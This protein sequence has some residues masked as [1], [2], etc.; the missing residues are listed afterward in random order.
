MIYLI[1]AIIS[2]A[3]IAIIMRLSEKHISNNTSMLASNYLMCCILAVLFTGATQFSLSVKGVNF[4]IGLGLIGGVLYLAGFLLYQWNIRV[5]GVTLSALFMKMGVIISILTAIC[6]FNEVPKPMQIVGILIAFVAIPVIQLEKGAGRV[7]SGAG[8][9][10]LFVVGGFTDALSKVYEELGSAS[11]KNT[12]LLFTF[13][14]AFILCV[15][16]CIFRKQK[17]SKADFGFGLLIGIPNYLSARFL[18]YSLADVP[19]VIVYPMYSVGTIITVMLIS[20]FV[21]KEKLSS[22]QII[23]LSMILISLALLNI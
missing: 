1:L 15:C 11:L 23:A 8:L 12:F 18:L 4:A 14:S 16:L 9:I 21:F 7:A 13:L 6:F 5:N 19:A 10:L 3:A 17:I 22:R 2:S 20:S